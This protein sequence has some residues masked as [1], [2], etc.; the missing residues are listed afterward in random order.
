[1]SALGARPFTAGDVDRV[2]ALERAIFGDPW[3]KRS[4]QEL[5]D[6]EHI[7]GFVL[8]DGRGDL[9]GYAFCSCVSEEGEIL[10]LAVAPELRRKGL[11]RVLLDACL[12]WMADRGAQRVFLEVRRSNG[13]AIAMY[14]GQGFESIGVRRGYYRKPTEDAVTMVLELAPRSARK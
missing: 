6:L 8:G 4:F 3:S 10:N 9:A 11:G 14:E 13:A 7:Q 12:R 2:A 5:L 1:M